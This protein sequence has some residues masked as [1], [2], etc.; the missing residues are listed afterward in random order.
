MAADGE[1]KM[2]NISAAYP[3]F[4][5]VW[6]L[7]IARADPLLAQGSLTPPAGP[8][9]PTMK[10]LQQVEPRID[11]ATLPGSATAVRTISQSGS[12]Y[13]SGQI[14]GASGKDAIEITASGVTLDLN[15]FLVAG[16]G[17]NVAIRVTASYVSVR[18]GVISTGLTST[19]TFLECESVQFADGGLTS[20]NHL[21]V[22]KCRFDSNSNIVATD[23][24]IIA[25]CELAGGGRIQAGAHAQILR[26]LVQGANGN[27][28]AAGASAVV[29]GTSSI[30]SANAGI[31]AGDGSTL[32]DC[33]ATRSIG[34]GIVAGDGSSL[35]GCVATG[36]QGGSGIQAGN[37]SI[38]SHC[39]ATQNAVQFGISVASR[40]VIADC[41]ATANTDA[42]TS[43]FG[44]RAGGE[45]TVIRCTAS[46]NTSTNAAPTGST[47]GGISVSN[48]STVK[49][50]TVTGNMG[51]GILLT[52]DS[53]AIGNTADS[54]GSSVGSG[55]GIHM[56]STD[57]RV[58]GNHVTDNDRGIEADS[59]GSA[60]LRNT[61]S[62]NS[63]NWEIAAG[64][65]FFAINAAVTGAAVSGSSGGT[66]PGSLDPSVNLSF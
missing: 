13:L 56:T 54:N 3:T 64:N 43:S 50:C 59:G 63:V 17:P 46:A 53:H 39:A 42:N 44:I 2:K 36:S 34:N 29:T 45:A 62:G 21:R 14:N 8:P 25:D 66:A 12:Y 19:S 55:A 38:L 48:S 30:D 40:A 60:I 11:V 22:S 4:V 33:V 24:A 41:V 28:V 9:A 51:D 26:C 7:F 15:G 32:T 47:G 37:G 31:S 6:L 1:I 65:V 5:L 16:V 61:A 35:K 57:N 23:S 49:D 20:G 27:G 18:N 58:E 10:T 52:F